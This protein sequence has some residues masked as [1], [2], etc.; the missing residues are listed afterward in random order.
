[1][2]AIIIIDVQNGFMKASNA[3]LVRNINRLLNKHTFE[4]A[5]YTQ[6]INRPSSMFVKI[7]NWHDMQEE[8]A[9]SIATNIAS[10]ATI[11]QKSSYG[12]SKKHLEQLTSLNLSQIYL[13]GT[14]I[15]ACIL[16]IA[17]Q[18]FDAGIK[19]MFIADCCDTSS[20]NPALKEGA[21][22][23]IKRS[24]GASSIVTSK[25]IT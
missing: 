24:F 16:A 19:P 11:W 21:L 1:M 18:L 8:P 22:A 20:I 23:I 9:T 7:L 10:N 3:Y 25:Q 4:H 14:D 12:L 6:F 5:F 13:C 17:F 15:D 2:K